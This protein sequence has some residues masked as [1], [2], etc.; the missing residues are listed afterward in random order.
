MIEDI[1]R[2]SEMLRIVIAREEHGLLDPN[3][4]HT[5]QLSRAI[6]SLDETRK[7]GKK[8]PSRTPRSILRGWQGGDGG[9]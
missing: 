7:D 3:D 6:R 4:G 5:E 2:L 1:S 8:R 9:E